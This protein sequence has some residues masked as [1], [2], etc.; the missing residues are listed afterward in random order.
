MINKIYRRELFL[1]NL[2]EII[3]NYLNFLFLNIHFLINNYFK[4]KKVYF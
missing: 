3:I 1:K 4:I 2:A